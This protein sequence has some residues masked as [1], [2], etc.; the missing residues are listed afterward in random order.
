MIKLNY[1]LEGVLFNLFSF[2]LF[3]EGLK[4]QQKL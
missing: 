4:L 2:V 1:Q 3:R